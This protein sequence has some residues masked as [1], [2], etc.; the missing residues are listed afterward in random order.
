MIKTHS[1]M[2]K[3]FITLL[4]LVVSHVSFSQCIPKMPMNANMEKTLEYEW[5]QKQVFESKQMADSE[6][7]N[8]WTHIGFGN[9]S[10]S[11][12][13]KHNGQSSLLLQSPVR[14]ENDMNDPDGRG[15][16]WG[17]SSAVCNVQGEDW[18]DWNR[19]SFWV[20]PDL[21]N[22]R[23]VSLSMIFHNDGEEKVPD[24]YDRNGLNYQILENHKWNKVYWEIAHLARD[25]VT[26]VE[27]RYR[28]QGSEPESS[29]TV[30][31]YFN[32]FSLEKIKADY[33][34]GWNVAED[35][36]A[37]N[38]IGYVTGKPKTALSS[39]SAE[40]KFSLLNASTKN[41]VLEKPVVIKETPVGEFGIMDFSEIDQE[42]TYILKTGEIETKPFKIG[43][44][45]NVYRNSNIKTINHFYSQRCGVPIAGIH[46][47][48]HEDWLCHHKD[49]SIVINGGWHDA[50]DLSQGLVNTTEAAYAMFLL[51]EKLKD[52]DTELAERILEEAVWGLE[53]ILRTLF[54]DGYRAVWSTMVIK[55]D[56]IIGTIDDASSEA[57]NNPEANLLASKTEALAA[58]VLENT[59]P[60]LALYSLNCAKEDWEFAI[61]AIQNL[62]VDLAGAALNTGIAL[63]EIT[64]DDKYKNAAIK[65][66]SYILECQQTANL[67][68]DIKL[69]GFF[70]RNSVKENILHYS[71]RGHEQDL[72]IGLVSLCELFPDDD[73]FELWNNAIILY[74]EYYKN[75][76]KYTDPY[77]MIPAGIYDLN[78]ARNN[79]EAEQIKSGFKLNDRYFM[80]SFPTWTALRGNSGTILSQVKGLTTAANYL[81]DKELK[82][83]CY[84]Q[85][86]WHLGMNPFCQ[87]LMYGEG[88]RFAAQY[89]ALSG[90]IVGGLP[91]GVQTHSNKDLP[92]W[93]A[94]NCY[95]WKEIW[96][97][98]SSRWL[99][100]MTDYLGEF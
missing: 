10:I 15:V 9:L 71:H 8:E 25:K 23:I 20:Y 11:D 75:I 33:Y 46:S 59:N 64:N 38:H 66:G 49:R 12:V 40:Q 34:E 70:Y 41:V 7:L 68:N 14:G 78:S 74:A 88:Y 6:N 19:I 18:F 79:V 5:A 32:E 52:T 55:T 56:G 92:Y 31:Y 27:F 28:L 13:Q 45:N 86:D 42:G 69:K 83:M 91:V 30:K 4:T 65:Y 24:V 89:S 100:I 90:N 81:N 67:S 47:Y 2:N 36:L 95:N 61:A 97:H 84:K 53:W 1:H 3:I 26:G 22:T 43:Q 82:D 60:V 50:G 21:P 48:C 96:V 17:V 93:P 58:K 44:F 76:S 54:G 99:W 29:D 80:K 51:S 98:P 37:Y 57:Q 39:N 35:Y 16:P 94:E 62:T 63:Y 72:V 87:S 73:D 85:L 77:Y